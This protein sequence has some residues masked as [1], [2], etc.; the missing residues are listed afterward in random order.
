MVSGCELNKM[1]NLSEGGNHATVK[2]YKVII[3]SVMAEDWKKKWR[4]N[5]V[6]VEATKRAKKEYHLKHGLPCQICGANTL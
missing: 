4:R 5:E 1:S 2:D 3:L 6:L